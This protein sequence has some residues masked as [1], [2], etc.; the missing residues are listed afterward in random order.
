MTARARNAPLITGIGLRLPGAQGLAAAWRILAE[1][2]STVSKVNARGFD[3]ELYLDP[4]PGRRGKTVTFAAGQLENL[5]HFDPGVFD[6]SPREAMEMDPQQRLM[7]MAVQEAVD[8]AGLDVAE[9]A[10]PRTGVF[11]GA[12]IVENLSPFYYDAA[13]GGSTFTLGNTLAIIANR[14][15]ATFDFRGP[16]QVI[17]TACSSAL[18]AL[19]TAAGA[20]RRG[21][22]DMAVVGGVHVVRTPGGFVGLP[23]PPAVWNRCGAFRNS[24]AQSNFCKTAA[25]ILKH[26]SSRK[27]AYLTANACRKTTDGASAPS[28]HSTLIKRDY[29]C[30]GSNRATNI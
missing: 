24:C 8:D 14:V 21:E 25:R 7:L 17:D 28:K 23:I 22:L 15:S 19:D 16:S 27:I 29:T 12:S 9:L 26:S 10:G 11:I 18:T 30:M 2:R 5:W 6:I 13:R 3:P 20:L 1:G 4:K